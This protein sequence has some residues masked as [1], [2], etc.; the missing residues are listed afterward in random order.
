[1]KLYLFHCEDSED[2]AA[3][4]KAHLTAHLAH[5]AA[6]IDDYA[7]AGPLKA[8]GGTN[9]SALVIKAENEAEARAKFEADPYFTAG[10]WRTVTVHEF[11]AV[12]GDWVG[13]AAW[14]SEPAG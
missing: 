8:D 10:V 5:V 1:V 14:Q 3:L 6:H 7:V 12:A 4:R 2:G 11:A 13:G 9:G